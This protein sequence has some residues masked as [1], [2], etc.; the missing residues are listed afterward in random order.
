MCGKQVL[1]QVKPV[2]S[3][4]TVRRTEDEVLEDEVLE[5]GQGGRHVSLT[6]SNK[7]LASGFCS[8]DKLLQPH[9]ISQFR[10]PAENQFVFSLMTAH[11]LNNVTANMTPPSCC[12]SL[13]S[14]H[15]LGPRIFS[16]AGAGAGPQSSGGQQ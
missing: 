2:G 10:K 12:S 6:A 16:G 4:F 15:T 13:L 5:D 14:P 11:Y 8:K 9:D 3:Q 7:W 1:F